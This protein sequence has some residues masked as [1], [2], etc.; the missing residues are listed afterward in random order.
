M[1]IDIYFRFFLN[2][3]GSFPKGSTRAELRRFGTH[4]NTCIH[5]CTS[6][7]IHIH[8]EIFTDIYIKM[9]PCHLESGF[10]APKS[11]SHIEFCVFR[12]HSSRCIH[13]CIIMCI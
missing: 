1:C 11:S 9:F 4:R 8:T 12:L 3:E 6:M 2:V 10:L 7:C 5:K 13:M